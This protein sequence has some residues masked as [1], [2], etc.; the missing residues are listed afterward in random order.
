MLMLPTSFGRP[1]ERFRRPEGRSAFSLVEVV[2]VLVI[3]A[4]VGGAAAARL[5]SPT[6]NA[7]LD[8][9]AKR[10]TADMAMARRAART[11]STTVRVRFNEGG[12]SY[13]MANV[14][15]PLTGVAGYGVD[16][17]RNPYRVG[18]AVVDDNGD[19]AVEFNARGGADAPVTIILQSARRQRGFRIDATGVMTE[20]PPQAI[21]IVPPA[22]GEQVMVLP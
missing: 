18:L 16:L 2:L 11:G 3:L 15:H 14:P 13:R 22:E 7:R 20:L 9:A 8:A 10:L 19:S 5:G 12:V 6:Q 21:P 4:V 17:S 1:S